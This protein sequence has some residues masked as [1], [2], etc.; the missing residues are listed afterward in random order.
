ML[1]NIKYLCKYICTYQNK[2]V[3]LHHHNNPLE[4]PSRRIKSATKY[5]K[6]QISNLVNGSENTLRNLAAEKYVTNPVGFFNGKNNTP[7]KGG[8]TSEARKEIANKVEMENPSDMHIIANG[9]DLTLTR[10]NSL[11]G[12]SWRWEA[13]ITA[14]QYAAITRTVA[15]EWTHK[16]ADNRYGLIIHGDCSV[17]VWASSGKKGFFR[18]LGEEFIEI[19]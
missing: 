6:T 18:I 9:I 1:Y 11:S 4:L 16:G 7:Q 19:I 12:K 5:M 15:P 3:T 2:D 10:H 13:D 8:S 17:E 14:E